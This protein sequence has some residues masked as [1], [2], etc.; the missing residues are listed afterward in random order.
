MKIAVCIYGRIQG[1]ENTYQNFIDNLDD[2]IEFDIYLSSDNPDEE[3]FKNFLKIYNPKKFNIEKI[4]YNLNLKIDNEG[5][6]RQVR[7]FTN[8]QRVF[9]LIE[10]EYD[11]VLSVRCDLWYSSKIT[12]QKPN[13]NTLYIPEGKDY[14]RGLNDQIA[15]GDMCSM[16]KYM[17]LINNLEKF[18]NIDKINFHPET[19]HRKNAEFY[20]LKLVRFPLN[21]Q[22]KRPANKK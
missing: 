16:R 8:K 1:C 22:I 11:G 17:N 13:D 21:Y 10:G 4:N 5:D 18:V 20:E 19:L 3:D 6:D 12:L 7:H 15:F 9:N 2:D 14:L